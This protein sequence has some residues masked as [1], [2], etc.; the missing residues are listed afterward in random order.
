M[1][2]E[3]CGNYPQRNADFEKFMS[4]NYTSTGNKVV[5][6]AQNK[7]HLVCSFSFLPDI[8]SHPLAA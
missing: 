4:N 5:T 6:A 3:R 2:R 7:I 8:P 1:R